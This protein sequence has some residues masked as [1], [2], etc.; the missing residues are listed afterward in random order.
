MENG[1]P[2]RVLAIAAHPD[3]IEWSCA[4]TLA[5]FRQQGAAV[6]IAIA[7]RGDLGGSG[8]ENLAATRRDEASRSAAIIG[9]EIFFFGQPDASI[10]D[11]AATREHFLWTIR[12]FNPDLI[13]THSPTDY[14]H[15]HRVVSQL[16]TDC[17]WF[18]ASPGHR[19]DPPTTPVRQPVPIMYF[20]NLAGMDFQPTHLVDISSVIETK[21][22]ML[23]C[24]QSQLNRTD[25]GMDLL[26]EMAMTL[27]KLRGMQC[28]VRYAEGFAACG[29]FGRR[30]PE[31]IFPAG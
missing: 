21:Q 24:H 20:D 17:S 10:R 3:D 22:A 7:C 12:S 2:R 8:A 9:A 31:P 15:D 1:L 5:L 14:H 11:D 13:L 25:S 4:G 27:S 18:A 28:N 23:R 6:G 26:E 29:R 30:M 19:T 16:A